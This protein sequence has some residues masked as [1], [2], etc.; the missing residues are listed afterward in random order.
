MD[1]PIT[2]CIALE[3]E[4]YKP[5]LHVLFNEAI[6]DIEKQKKI[7][8]KKTFMC[9]DAMGRPNDH[10]N[11]DVKFAENFGI[12]CFSPESIFYSKSLNSQSK[13]NVDKIT[14]ENN[15][16]REVVIMVGYP[17]S[18]KSTIVKNVFEPAGYFIANGD[19]LK[20]STKMIKEAKKH[21]SNK[22]VVFDATN[23]SKRKR[24][25]Y[26]QFAKE[27]KLCNT[28]SMHSCQYQFG[29]IAKKK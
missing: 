16:I 29:R 2:I 15:N 27:F 3:K 23:P 10:S 1:I 25:E 9:G 12:P 21:I 20:T 28:N 18:G 5:N 7:N 24:L 6:S 19:L 22:S 13:E 26:I 8:K 11:C 14:A 17:G 4:H